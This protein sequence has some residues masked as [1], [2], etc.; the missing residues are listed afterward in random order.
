MPPMGFILPRA[1]KPAARNAD[2]CLFTFDKGHSISFTEA[3]RSTLIIGGTGS[4]KTS[5][6]VLPMCHSLLKA[7]FGGLIID[8]KGNMGQQVRQIARAC[9]READI[10]EFGSSSHACKTNLLEGMKEHETASL[11][12][13]L[14]TS[15]VAHDSNVAWH[16]KGARMAQDIATVLKG[17]SRKNRKCHFSRQFQPTLKGVAAMLHNR[18]M[19]QNLWRLYLEEV[20]K[21]QKICE[22]VTKAHYLYQAESFAREVE[23]QSFHIFKMPDKDGTARSKENF[24]EQITW[25]LQR[26]TWQLKNLASTHN[27]LERFS[28]LDDDAVPI[29]FYE[30]VYR[31]KKV[32]LVHFGPD[33]GPAASV[34]ARIIKER[35]YMALYEKGMKLDA[36][37][38]TFM[39]N[40]EFQN[41]MDVSIQNRFS[42]MEL[43]SVSREFRNINIV[44]TQSVVSLYA[45][46]SPTA[47]A[48]LLAN[49][50][51]KI[52]LQTRDPATLKWAEAFVDLQLPSIAELSRGEC[53]VDML[54]AS[55]EVVNVLEGVQK[56]YADTHLLLH[57]DRPEMTRP[58]YKSDKPREST[59]GHSRSISGLPCVVEQLLAQDYSENKGKQLHILA[60]LTAMREASVQGKDYGAEGQPSRESSRPNPSRKDW[61]E[62]RFRRELRDII[63]TL[64]TGTEGAKVYRTMFDIWKDENNSRRKG[65]K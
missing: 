18:T 38:Y 57:C 24:D 49:C 27:L 10:V 17:L 63:E 22:N 64:P 21:A 1:A 46:G 11:F 28:S 45:K 36:G 37:Q 43:F 55:G 54:D 44:A 5:S 3:V 26:I 65:V 9:G 20:R 23:S 2:E 58:S 16:Q 56:A 13:V 51:N 7:S 39:V 12:N 4:G 60:Q 47:V 34:L 31:Q 32:V 8:V 15:G 29:N 62:V 6:L 35:F 48:S 61:E 19:A 25:M 40:D 42:D 30:L 53:L 59:R 41:T 33:C 50:T 52:L 14:A